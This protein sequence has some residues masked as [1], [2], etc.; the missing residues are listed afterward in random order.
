M[1]RVT[2]NVPAPPGVS[3]QVVLELPQ[4]IERRQVPPLTI[5]WNAPAW[6]LPVTWNVYIRRD[7]TN[8]SFLGS[9]AGTNTAVNFTNYVAPLA[10]SVSGVDASG[11]EW[12]GIE[13]D[14]GCPTNGKIFGSKFYW[15]S[16]SNVVYVLSNAPLTTGP[17]TRSTVVSNQSGLR[18]VPLPSTTGRISLGIEK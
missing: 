17:W 5:G 12:P 2:N 13:L 18:S 3:S 10:F 7:S 15:V 14:W 16:V 11:K 4:A 9:I 8:W 6:G 1:V